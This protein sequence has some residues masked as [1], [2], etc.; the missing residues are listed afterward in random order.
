MSLPGLFGWLIWAHLRPRCAPIQ[1]ALPESIREPYTWFFVIV[2]IG[3]LA[4]WLTLDYYRRGFAAARVALQGRRFLA[5]ILLLAVV[6]TLSIAIAVPGTRLASPGAVFAIVIAVVTIVGFF[7]TLAKLE[8]ILSGLHSYEALVDRCEEMVREE[9]RFVEATDRRGKLLIAANAVTFGNISAKQTYRGLLRALSKAFKDA[10]IEVVTLSR[11]WEWWIPRELQAGQARAVDSDIAQ[12]PAEGAFET[13]TIVEIMATGL[14]ALYW[15]W[16]DTEDWDDQ[17]LCEPY[18]Q[19]VALLQVLRTAQPNSTLGVRKKAFS[20][21][22]SHV[23]FH[24]VITSKRA[25]L[26]HVVDFPVGAGQAPRRKLHVVGT[27]TRESAVI[28]KLEE[29]FW[30][31]TRQGASTRMIPGGEDNGKEAE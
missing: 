25:L 9:I 31:H 3:F 16:R 19:A 14:G 12:L 24:M 27:E 22:N 28:E 10:R 23:P 18:Y 4:F 1:A 5:P 13:K 7:F 2:T 21:G 26:F 29:A 8:E 11:A 30:Y 17:K 15:S 6:V 20:V